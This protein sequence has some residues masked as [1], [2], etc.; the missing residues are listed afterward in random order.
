MVRWG[1]AVCFPL[2]GLAGGSRHDTLGR[3]TGLGQLLFRLGGQSAS[4]QSS[5]IH[6]SSIQIIQYGCRRRRRSMS[7]SNIPIP[8]GAAPTLL[9]LLLLRERM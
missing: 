6:C 1:C 8:T 2:R 9:L 4:R 5:R 7:S 3:G